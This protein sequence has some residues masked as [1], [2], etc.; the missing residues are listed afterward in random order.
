VRKLYI[1]VIRWGGFAKNRDE[2]APIFNQIGEWLYFS[3]DSWVVYTEK[4]SMQIYGILTSILTTA[5]YELIFEIVP[6]SRFGF[7][8]EW[9]WK[10]IEDRTPK[11][12][13]GL[14]PP[15]FN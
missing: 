12:I 10:W 9:L 15:N 13:T 11:L 7:A 6:G 2:M 3:V 8:P 5:D 14:A 4:N 1:V